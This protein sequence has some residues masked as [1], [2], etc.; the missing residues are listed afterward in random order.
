M[1]HIYS[2][3]LLSHKRNKTGSFV[4]TWIH[5]ESVTQN[6]VSQKEKNRHCILPHIYM[7]SRKMVQINLFPEH[8]FLIKMS[9]C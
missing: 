5:L 4:E 6:D 7:D 3:I 1:V 2:G 9:V 8:L